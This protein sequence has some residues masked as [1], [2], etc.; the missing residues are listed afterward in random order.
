MIPF[1]EENDDK[2]CIINIFIKCTT[3]II[4]QHKIAEHLPLIVQ[5][6]KFVIKSIFS[7]QAINDD[8]TITNNPLCIL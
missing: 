5:S 8:C 3:V 6:Q 7:T 2:G 1:S 4:V